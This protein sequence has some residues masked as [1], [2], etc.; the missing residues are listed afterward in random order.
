MSKSSYSL[1][2]KS[3]NLSGWH[4][5]AALQW[6]AYV[7][8]QIHTNNYNN[9]NYYNYSVNIPYTTNNWGELLRDSSI[10]H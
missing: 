8:K 7:K 1:I 4:K 5:E 3:D 9:S 2:I 6:N 10:I